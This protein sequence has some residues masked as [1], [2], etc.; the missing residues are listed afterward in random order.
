MVSIGF[1][2]TSSDLNQICLVD[3]RLPGVRLPEV[4]CIP[5][6]VDA[7]EGG[8]VEPQPG[9]Q[10]DQASWWCRPCVVVVYQ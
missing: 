10:R 4:I 5:V 3:V 9:E 1:N 7:G 6:V 8:E 2:Q